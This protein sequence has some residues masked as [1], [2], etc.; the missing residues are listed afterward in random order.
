MINTQV[1]F[2]AALSDNMISLKC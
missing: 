1:H 2:Q